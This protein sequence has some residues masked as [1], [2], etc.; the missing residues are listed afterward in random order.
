MQCFMHTPHLVIA[1]CYISCKVEQA[2]LQLQNAATASWHTHCNTAH[3]LD[4]LRTLLDPL[5][6]CSP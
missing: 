6:S 1:A 2:W 3:L 5:P 4:M